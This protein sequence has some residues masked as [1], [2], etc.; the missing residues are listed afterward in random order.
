VVLEKARALLERWWREN[1]WNAQIAVTLAGVYELLGV[2]HEP[3]SG[4]GD[5]PSLPGASWRDARAHYQRSLD[6]WHDL[7][8]RNRL[9]RFYRS[10]TER[11][12]E[13]LL[14]CDTELNRR[15]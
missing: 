2:V 7:E 12:A 9:A 3:S 15:R 14:R 1:P 5:H 13:A 8:A 11:V 6:V 10:R 4:R